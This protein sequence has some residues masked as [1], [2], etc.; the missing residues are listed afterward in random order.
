MLKTC[1]VCRTSFHARRDARAC[2]PRCKKRLQR[3][4]SAEET[5]K[6]G[7][8]DAQA[9]MRLIA[10]YIDDPQH[11][12]RAVNGIRSLIRQFAGYVPGYMRHALGAEISES[13]D[14]SEII[15]HRSSQISLP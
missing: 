1:P 15:E 7:I 11:H 13:V 8:L 2:S 4:P 12:A 3:A 14:A 5:I 10:L 9:A 6:E